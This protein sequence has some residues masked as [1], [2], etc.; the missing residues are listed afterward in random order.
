[1]GDELNLSDLSAEEFLQVLNDDN[2]DSLIN[3]TETNTPGNLNSFS[4][5][6]LLE[7]INEAQKE[8]EMVAM[9]AD[10]PLQYFA[11][12]SKLGLGD[13]AVFAGTYIDAFKSPFKHLLQNLYFGSEENF[14][15]QNEKQA[16]MV[17]KLN[18]FK[19]SDE[20]NELLANGETDR[21]EDKLNQISSEGGTRGLHWKEM[22]ESI[23]LPSIPFTEHASYLSTF[24]DNMNKN[25]EIVSRTTGADPTMLPSS[26]SIA[27][28]MVGMSIRF[29]SDPSFYLPGAQLKAATKI[30]FGNLNPTFL[31]NAGQAIKDTAIKYS[32]RFFRNGS[33]AALMGTGTVLGASGGGKLEKEFVGTDSGVGETIGSFVGGLMA[34]I[35]QVPSKF[36]YRK[37]E[38]AFRN[39]QFAKQYPDEVAKQYASSGAKAIFENMQKELNPERLDVL[40]KDFRKIGSMLETTDIPLL[41][42]AADSPTA[43]AELKRLMQTNPGFRKDIEDEVY[44][45]GIAIDKHADSIFGTRYAPVE[46]STLPEKL[47]ARG[48]K[49]IDLRFEL[50]KKIEILD[51]SFIPKNADDIGLQVQNLIAKRESFAREEM[52]PVYATIDKEAAAANVVMPGSSTTDLYSYVKENNLRDLFGKQSPIDKLVMKYLEPKKN[53]EKV[54]VDRINPDLTTT[55]VERMRGDLAPS[56]PEYIAPQSIDLSWE[57][58]D[59]LK[60]SINRFGR[61]NLTQTERRQLN[62]FK[63]FFKEKRLEMKGTEKSGLRFDDKIALEL[64]AKLDAADVL[65]YEKIGIPYSQEGILQINSKKYATEI[66]P[67]L[68]KNNE[69]LDQFLSVAGLEGVEIAQNAYILQM[70]DKVMKDGVF[71][72]KK[73][74]ALMR[75]DRRILDSLPGVKKMLEKSMVDQ[76]ELMLKRDAIN[77]QATDFK[78]EIADH[79]LI[80]SALSP[81][82]PNLAARLVKGDMGFYKKIQDDLKL[83]DTSSAEI[84][85]NNIQREY[86]TQVFQTAQK[87]KDGGMRFLLDPANEKMLNTLFDKERI[88]IFKKLSMVS[89]NLKKIDIADLNAKSVAQQVDPVSKRLPGVSSQYF[90]AQIRDR[91]SSVGMKVIRV[92]THINQT[93]LQSRLD[94]TVQELLLHPDIKKLDVWGKK[95]NWK[96]TEKSFK[97]FSNIIAEMI[98]NYV[99]GATETRVLQEFEEE[100]KNRIRG[101][102]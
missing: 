22:L 13:T 47:R 20:Y 93:Q 59:S 43:Q 40:I 44:K 23:N 25:Q 7:F 38:I 15:L 64:N 94:T 74:R 102:N 72:P 63:T 39:R 48:Q 92:V 6:G 31:D 88:D 69:S 97:T 89:D 84:V 66:A 8:N 14:K 18:G 45:L 75:R 54:I 71:N 51:L 5:E 41:V 73:V 82:Y 79:F 95:N 100:N 86:V 49:L 60:K 52:K 26:D 76:G 19:N 58:M 85:R 50:D 80:S 62:Q 11:N 91:V 57:Q 53:T 77:N 29:G 61:E 68:F 33:T 34:P 21:I 56:H 37:L 78:K 16:D 36:A 83:L 46:L 90:F 96:L 35:I 4:D 27:E 87:N 12:S 10:N 9:R 1:M 67:V 55:Q 17:N 24:T 2:A 101:N 98:P 28:K 81:N 65:Y 3:S 30:P 32:G 99:H 70:Y 42:M